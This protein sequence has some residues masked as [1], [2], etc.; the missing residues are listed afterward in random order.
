MRKKT[1]TG[2][3]QDFRKKKNEKGDYWMINVETSHADVVVEEKKYCKNKTAN[4][5]L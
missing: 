4:V 2:L 5:N 3:Q 1:L